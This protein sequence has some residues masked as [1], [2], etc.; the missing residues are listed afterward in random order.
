MWRDDDYTAWIYIMTCED[1]PGLVKVGLS[2]DP[3]RRA[4]E[5]RKQGAAL[6][7]IEYARRVWGARHVERK[8]HDFLNAYHVRGESFRCS[9]SEATG[10]ICQ[11]AEN[12]R[13][14]EQFRED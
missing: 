2:S 8:A 5:I 13:I 6:P 12:Q 11:A 4:F 14:E 1:R 10:A 3:V 7:T 9:V